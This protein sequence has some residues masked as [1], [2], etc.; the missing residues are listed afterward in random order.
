LII[1]FTFH[2]SL[3]QFFSHIVH[4]LSFQRHLMCASGHAVHVSNPFIELRCKDSTVG[5]AYMRIDQPKRERNNGEGDGIG[6][7]GGGGGGGV[8]GEVEGCGDKSGDVAP[9]TV[10]IDVKKMVDANGGGGVGGG[11]GGG[12]ASFAGATL[13]FVVYDRRST[14]DRNL[15]GYVAVNVG[16][17]LCQLRVTVRID[18]LLLSFYYLYCSTLVCMTPLRCHLRVA[19]R[20]ADGSAN[21][22]FFRLLLRLAVFFVLF[23]CARNRMRNAIT[24][25]SCVHS[26][27]SR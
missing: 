22:H 16:A 27:A 25:D 8:N 10:T 1:K 20:I 5:A 18:C 2:T 13:S 26:L 11:G 23:C 7:G 9:A 15:I 21:R 24:H 12:V 14:S 6:G 19:V 17:L 3:V 4:L